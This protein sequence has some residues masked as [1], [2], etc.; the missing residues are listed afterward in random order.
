MQY[1]FDTHS[2]RITPSYSGERAICPL[3]D[4]T[5]IG[6]CGSIRIWHW[7]HLKSKD[8]DTW[9]EGETEWH[10]AWKERF[11]ESWREIV[12][13]KDGKKHRADVRTDSGLVIEF[14]NSPIGP[15]T[16]FEREGFYEDMIWVLNAKSFQDKLIFKPTADYKI[17]ELFERNAAKYRGI[18]Y[19]LRMNEQELQSRLD[20]LRLRIRVINEQISN[21]RVQR[22]LIQSHINDTAKHI[23]CLI[24]SW[25]LPSTE[26]LL[27]KSFLPSDMEDNYK[28]ATKQDFEIERIVQQLL[29]VEAR[30]KEIDSYQVKM[31]NGVPYSLVPFEKIYTK[32]YASVTARSK[33]DKNK[34][35]VFESEEDFIKFKDQS[36]AHY[37][38]IESEPRIKQLRAKMA[39]L[40]NSLLIVI[41]FKSEL[42]SDLLKHLSIAFNNHISEIDKLTESL[43]KYE[44]ECCILEET[45]GQQKLEITK[46]LREVSIT[47][48]KERT[49]EEEKLKS[50]FGNHFRFSWK[51]RRQSWDEA[52]SPIFLDLGDGDLYEIVNQSEV[53]RITLKSFLNQYGVK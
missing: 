5:L 43:S 24:K 21:L 25:A 37:F 20:G 35:L 28:K 11:P 18:E 41:S 29:K 30:L 49:L 22:D 7:Q 39:V 4:G 34:T 2:K 51:N 1:A 47:L 48:N 9:K 53:N 36:Q 26:L 17:T 38:L 42:E 16:I 52:S 6:K 8:C 12:I 31:L 40:E 13:E 3:C 45:Y 46:K 33:T 27:E 15:D 50:E 19:S 10:R 23:T 44:K 32:N 14:Q